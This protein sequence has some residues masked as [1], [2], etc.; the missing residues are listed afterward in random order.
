MHDYIHYNPSL[1]SYPCTQ[2][3]KKL[4]FTVMAQADL[5]L[6]ITVILCYIGLFIYCFLVV[7]ILFY[8]IGRPLKFIGVWSILSITL[9]AVFYATLAWKLQTTSSFESLYIARMLYSLFWVTGTISIYILFIE[10][11]QITFLGTNHAI[12]SY[13]YYGLYFGCALFLLHWFGFA[14]CY[15]LQL[16]KTITSTQY[17]FAEGITTTIGLII[18]F[19]LS[20]S[21]IAIFIQKLKELSIEVG[22]NGNDKLLNKDSLSRSQMKIVSSMSKVT[23]LSTVAIVS[24]QCLFLL[25]A[26]MYWMQT[27]ELNNFQVMLLVI[28][29]IVNSICVV[30]NF[31]FA[32]KWY[33]RMCC[34][35]DYCCAKLCAY[36]TEQKWNQYKESLLPQGFDL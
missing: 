34:C 24:T 28:D 31:D 14:T 32:G 36:Q 23:I 35:C 22:A 11:L 29:A 2:V 5:S 13:V 17:Y 18:D 1:H 4:S 10:R 6:V 21:I 27:T 15:Y 25:S 12:S 8:H 30:L 26:T 16:T 33:R 7:S 19:V 20:V 9:S 3:K